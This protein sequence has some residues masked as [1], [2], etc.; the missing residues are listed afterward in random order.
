MKLLG[1]DLA[2][3]MHLLPT[4]RT[5]LLIVGKVIF[6][7]LAWQVCWQR[8]AATL[9]ARGSFAEW[10]ACV[11]KIDDI[12]VFAVGIILTATLF[13]FIEEAINMLFAARRKTVKPCAPAP[14]QV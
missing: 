7:A 8:L 11:R 13:R 9:F 5:S 2:H 14:P 10:Q 12:V 4:A 1:N 3:A 6:D